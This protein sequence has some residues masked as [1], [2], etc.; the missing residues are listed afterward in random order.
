M[1]FYSSN[2]KLYSSFDKRDSLYLAPIKIIKKP[3][4]VNDK[5]FIM[6]NRT[7]SSFYQSQEKFMSPISFFRPI[8]RDK[9]LFPPFSS[10]NKK[11]KKVVDEIIENLLDKRSFISHTHYKKDPIKNFVR[12]E[13]Y[14]CHFLMDDKNQSGGNTKKLQESKLLFLT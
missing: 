1:A 14:T 4:L 9:N 3:K 7:Q 2:I 11:K 5:N 12:K 6:L 8:S 10:R 13:A